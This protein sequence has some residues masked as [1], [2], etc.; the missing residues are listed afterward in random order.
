MAGLGYLGLGMTLT[1]RRHGTLLPDLNSEG[2][3]RGG[4]GWQDSLGGSEQI[5]R[6]DLESL[7]LQVLGRTGRGSCPGTPRSWRMLSRGKEVWGHVTFVFLSFFKK[8]MFL[9]F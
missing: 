8:K 4:P 3:G 6:D 7:K 5:P 2:L 9:F 1:N